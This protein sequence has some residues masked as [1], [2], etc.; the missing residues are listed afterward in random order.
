MWVTFLQ[1]LLPSSLRKT[2]GEFM[3]SIRSTR[4]YILFLCSTAVLFLSACGMG[5]PKKDVV[6][7]SIKK[8]MPVNFEILAI[9]RVKD[10][11]GLNEVVVSVGNQTVVFYTDQKAKYLV[12]GSIVA[13]ETN[14]NLTMETQKK[15][16]QK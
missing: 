11:P 13:T 14:Q 3:M 4:L 1:G 16:A 15:Y 5:T 12:S 7:A 8:I 10:I 2:Y 9:N 6:A